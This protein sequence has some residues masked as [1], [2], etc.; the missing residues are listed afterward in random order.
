M[1]DD[2]DWSRL[3]APAAQAASP[4]AASPAPQA[5]A[6]PLALV[7]LPHHAVGRHAVGAAS[8]PRSRAP[9]VSSGAA[10]APRRR[11]PA[12]SSG[13]RAPKSRKLSAGV[14]N[15]VSA[16]KE[17]KVSKLQ[18]QV[19]SLKAKLSRAKV[20]KS[21]KAKQSQGKGLG[22]VF[23]KAT[24]SV[25]SLSNRYKMSRTSIRR[26]PMK[27]ASAWSQAQN[28][29]LRDATSSV[30]QAV[31]GGR[32]LM[33]VVD[34]RKWDEAKHVFA[35]DIDHNATNM[36]WTILRQRLWIGWWLAGVADGGRY[37]Q[38]YVEVILPPVLLLG[39]HTSGC[40]AEGLTG[41]PWHKEIEACLEVSRQ[42]AR[43]SLSVRECDAAGTNLKYTTFE[44]AKLSSTIPRSLHV[45]VTCA[46]HGVQAIV[47]K[48]RDAQADAF[49][50]PRSLYGDVM[51]SYAV[52]SALCRQGNYYLRAVLAIDEVLERMLR[53]THSPPIAENACHRRWLCEYLVFKP[54]G[55]RAVTAKAKAKFT[56]LQEDCISHFEFFRVIGCL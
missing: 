6:V 55:A 37:E 56:Q 45:T 51:R 14:S 47:K 15:F 29:M 30:Q 27:F 33:L 46:I 21:T 12:V 20:V 34:K 9:A 3:A 24:R 18:K 13:P 8:A 41:M 23:S 42:L 40:L 1:A 32:P 38:H 53:I 4:G 2:V 22:V 35:L 19:E 5:P 49:A 26:W 31:R 39:S 16:S 17:R 54:W 43:V 11:A 36:G 48:V 25:S 7:L 50:K 28:Q 44:Q 52:L 10:S